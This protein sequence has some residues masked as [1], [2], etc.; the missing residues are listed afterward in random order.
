MPNIKS[1]RKRLKVEE[2]RRQR[3]RAVN[4]KVKTA[5]KNF[6][7]ILLSG[8]KEQAEAELAKTIKIID[9]AAA[10]G[11]LH[12][13]TAARKKSILARAFNKAV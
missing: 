8:D 1:A 9:Q 13:N 11:V 7:N 3:N 10:K 12:K 2:K 6:D 4:S 5:I